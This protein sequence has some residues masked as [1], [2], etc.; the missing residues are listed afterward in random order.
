MQIQMRL[1]LNIYHQADLTH[2]YT[3]RLFHCCSWASPFSFGVSGIFS[4]FLLFGW[5]ILLATI[6]DPDQMPHN[7]ASD[8]GL[9]CLL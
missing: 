1:L 5:K 9:H 8:L 3:G 7:V 6:E 4:G 2:L